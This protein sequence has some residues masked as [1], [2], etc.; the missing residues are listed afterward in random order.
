MVIL[1]GC[2]RAEK[3]EPPLGGRIAN[4][5]HVVDEIRQALE[6]RAISITVSFD[7]GQEIFAELDEAVSGWMERA[8]ENTESPTQGDYIRYQYGGYSYQSE[9]SLRDGRYRYKV[10][11][12]PVYYSTQEEEEQVSEAFSRLKK[13]LGIHFWTSGEKKTK[14]VYEYLTK[15]VS[16]DRVHGKNP[17]SHI[18]STAY[19]ALVNK[20]ATCQGYCAAMYRLLKESG[21]DCRIIT[22]QAGDEALH[23]WVAVKIKGEWLYADPTWDAGSEGWE[24]FLKTIDDFPDHEMVGMEG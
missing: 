4:S 19:A 21:L 14:A 22:G 17:Y 9:Y 6:R 7:Y 13:E 15:E 24:Y 5:K 11:I 1:A 8:L 2:G 18:G 23:A 16:Y 10:K 3:G 12:I 20:S